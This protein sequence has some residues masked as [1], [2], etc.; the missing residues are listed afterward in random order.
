M[1]DSKREIPCFYLKAKTNLSNLAAFR[2]GPCRKAG[3]KAGTNDFFIKA[4]AKAIE[5]YPLFA[6]Q[7]NDDSIKIAN[8][9]NIGFAIETAQGLMQPVIKNVDKLSLSEIAKQDQA[10]TEKARNNTLTVND[11]KGSC[12]SLSSLG[13]FGLSEFIAIIPPSQTSI[14]AIGKMIDEPAM[15]DGQLKNKKMMNLTLSVDSR[16]INGDYAAKFLNCVVQYLEN[17]KNLVEIEI[18]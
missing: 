7:L 8:S 5:K 1:V 9:V 10:L 11:L 4:I 16:I 2:K 17:P 13:M 14:L 12:I 3:I 15:I 6:G 18:K